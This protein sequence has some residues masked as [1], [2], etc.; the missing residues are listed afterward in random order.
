VLF[1]FKTR[2]QIPNLNPPPKHCLSGNICHFLNGYFI[3]LADIFTTWLVARATT[4]SEP[5]F[6]AVSLQQCCFNATFN[7]LAYGNSPVR[8]MGTGSSPS[9]QQRNCS[10]FIAPILFRPVWRR[11][12]S[13]NFAQALLNPIH[14]LNGVLHRLGA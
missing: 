3:R 8:V 2:N 7:E 1:G 4:G 12:P 9:C 11:F 10:H 5:P 14:Q 6:L 13:A